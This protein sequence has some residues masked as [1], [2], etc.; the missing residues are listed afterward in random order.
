MI[1]YPDIGVD[2]VSARLRKKLLNSLGNQSGAVALAAYRL[3]NADGYDTFVFAYIKANLPN[4]ISV[5]VC[6]DVEEAI[7]ITPLCLSGAADLI[8]VQAHES[9][10]AVF[11]DV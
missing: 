3:C 5:A 8:W 9:D 6:G 4:E 2:N 7:S 11:S 1:V 10:G